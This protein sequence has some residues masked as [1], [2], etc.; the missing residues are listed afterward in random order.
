MKKGHSNSIIALL[1][2]LCLIVMA[3]CQS[4]EGKTEE[5]Q[6]HLLGEWHD[7]VWGYYYAFKEQGVVYYKN[8][9]DCNMEG[10][11]IQDGKN[12]VTTFDGKE[13]VMELIEGEK[14]DVLVEYMEGT[15]DV[16]VPYMKEEEREFY[17]FEIHEKVMELAEK[18]TQM[19]QGETYSIKDGF[20][21]YVKGIVV[22]YDIPG[23][24]IDIEVINSGSEM[25]IYGIGCNTFYYSSGERYG[26]SK[27]GTTFSQ[28]G[29]EGKQSRNVLYDIVSYSSDMKSIPEDK[30]E[31]LNG[32]DENKSFAYTEI[33]INEKNYWIDISEEYEEF[34]Q[35]M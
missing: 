2:V 15:E 31:Y 5:N 9:S 11:Y 21:F 10:T 34:L 13:Y 6:N 1:G 24:S 35:N 18:S 16:F 25:Q 19:I 8:E 30:A 27:N 12:I 22:D 32:R 26:M 4:K 17:D 23:I 29:V 3:G 7:G 20:E 28:F 33:H 14:C